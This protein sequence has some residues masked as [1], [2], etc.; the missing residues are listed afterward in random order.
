MSQEFGPPSA[1][2]DW[3]TR[4]RLFLKPR[5][6]TL[7]A[8]VNHDLL[9]LRDGKR[10][11]QRLQTFAKRL[12]AYA[13]NLAPPE[14]IIFT[15]TAEEIT[16]SGGADRKLDIALIKADDLIRRNIVREELSAL[17]KPITARAFV[18]DA[19][20]LPDQSD[21][22]SLTACAELLAF[23]ESVR[24]T[25]EKASLCAKLVYL[26]IA[27]GI[28]PTGIYDW[29]HEPHSQFNEHTPLDVIDSGSDQQN[30]ELLLFTEANLS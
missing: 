14:Q 28:S 20:A 10:T 2:K 29:L 4:Q 11:R 19:L 21:R 27:S 17:E 22:I 7:E 3:E 25:D 26:R 16:N 1:L 30:R 6:R 24:T 13:S 9:K 23:G 8:N 12:G 18:Y 5:Y 15:Q